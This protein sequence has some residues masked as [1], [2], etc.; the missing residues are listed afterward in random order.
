MARKR[1]RRKNKTRRRKYRGGSSSAVVFVLTNIAGFGSVTNFLCQAYIHAKE[2]GRDFFIE[3][4]SWQYGYKDGWH[5]Y[6][7]SLK[8]LPNPPPPNLEKYVHGQMGNVPNY[9]MKKYTSCI[10][11]IFVLNDDLAKRAQDYIDTMGKPYNALYVRRGDKVAGP[12][13]EVDSYPLSDIVKTMQLP[14]NSKLFLMTDD[15][16]TKEELEKMIPSIKIYTLTPPET[17]GILA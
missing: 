12:E 16:S 6:F 4:Q 2:T 3:N 11:E 14:D 8:N 9:P 17:K 1:S 5:D 15:Y 10:K 7:K 13:K